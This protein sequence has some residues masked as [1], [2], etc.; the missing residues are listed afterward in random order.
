MWFILCENKKA[1]WVVGVGG[2]GGVSLEHHQLLRDLLSHK[3]NTRSTS[4]NI[5]WSHGRRKTTWT[6]EGSLR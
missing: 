6:A 2:G 5:I 3:I 4:L 1:Q